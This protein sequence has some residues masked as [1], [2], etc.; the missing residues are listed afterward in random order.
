MHVT[1]S[2]PILALFALLSLVALGVRTAPDRGSYLE[3][4]ES[5]ETEHLGCH[6]G[7]PICGPDTYPAGDLVIVEPSFG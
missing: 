1:L 7:H 2:S 6:L 3:G 5:P 4:A